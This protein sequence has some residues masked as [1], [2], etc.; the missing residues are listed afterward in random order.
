MATLELTIIDEG[1]LF[2]CWDSLTVWEDNHKKGIVYISTNE[3]NEKSGTRIISAQDSS[4]YLTDYFISD[5]Y[6]IDYE[7]YTGYWI[8]KFLDEAKVSHGTIG[9]GVAISDNTQL[10]LSSA[11]DTIQTLLQYSGWY[12]YFDGNGAAIVG[13]MDVHSGHPTTINDTRIL[14]VSTNKN[15]SMLRNRAVVWGNYDVST[16]G[17]IFAD[18]SVN[19]PWNYDSID[20]R[21]VVISNS[22]IANQVDADSLAKKVLTEFARINYEKTIA[23]VGEVNVT[24]GDF[25][26]ISSM[27]WSGT[28][29]VTTLEVS[30]SSGGLITNLTL[31]QRCPRLFAFWGEIDDYVYIGTDG[32]GVWRKPIDASGW[33]SFN[34]L[35]PTDDYDISDL[36][37]NDKIFATIAGSGELYYRQYDSPGWIPYL[38]SGLLDENGTEISEVL[39]RGLTI[40][41]QTNNIIVGYNNII[42]SGD[43]TRCWVVEITPSGELVRDDIV[44]VA[45]GDYGTHIVDLDTNDVDNVISV[46]TGGITFVDSLGSRTNTWAREEADSTTILPESDNIDVYEDT[47]YV[48]NSIIVTGYTTVGKPILQYLAADRINAYYRCSR[49]FGAAPRNV[50]RKYKYTLNLTSPPTISTSYTDVAGP[51][52]YGN[53]GYSYKE[54]D[55]DDIIYCTGL[56]E[57]LSHTHFYHEV[58]DF[59]DSSYTWDYATEYDYTGLT[60]LSTYQ[61]G[62]K[63]WRGFY[64]ITGTTLDVYYYSYDQVTGAI[65]SY[66]NTVTVNIPGVTSL[67]IVTNVVGSLFSRSF[68]INKTGTDAIFCLIVTTNDSRILVMHGSGVSELKYTQVWAKP[69]EMGGYIQGYYAYG[70]AVAGDTNTNTGINNYYAF[71]VREGSA[72]PVYNYAGIIYAYIDDTFAETITKEFSPGPMDEAAT[73]LFYEESTVKNLS[74][75]SSKYSSTP[76]G[77]FGT[78]TI[79][80]RNARTQEEITPITPVGLG[81]GVVSVAYIPF[82]NHYDF[83]NILFITSYDG[84]NSSLTSVRADTGALVHIF[85]DIDTNVQNF[86][87]SNGFIVTGSTNQTCRFLYPSSR[88]YYYGSGGLIL[89][90]QKEVFTPI[91]TVDSL[92]QV[93]ISKPYPIEV[94]NIT[95]SGIYPIYQADTAS[96]D[97]TEIV[98]TFDTYDGRVFDVQVPDSFIIASGVV[99]SGLRYF[100]VVTGD[101]LKAYPIDLL[102]DSITV[103]TFSGEVNHLETTN[104]TVNPY[105]FVSTSGDNPTFLQRNPLESS[106]VDYS[107][108]IPSAEIT[109]IRC[110]DFL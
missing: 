92:Y 3:R 73:L 62:S 27:G 29:L 55:N 1:T 10:G 45:S 14:S 96:G 33:E 105:I 43:Y 88:E 9:T 38:P 35:L 52:W 101:Y 12:L 17:Q 102:S 74:L 59:S 107:I 94:F 91:L 65:T 66:T 60:M 90:Q 20:K 87:C 78:G 28:G 61:I 58:Y 53:T 48:L 4:K 81:N 76:L 15:D 24:V 70:T 8:E 37:I 71:R 110:D 84:V 98:P 86:F 75:I 16:S 13:S 103:A 51:A 50:M 63:I 100:G 22:A 77:V 21:A 6:T 19:T 82:V 68:A 106:F 109:I 49:A 36:Y 11:Y 56:Y 44:Y 26:H 89:R 34:E 69:E 64:K 83:D 30:F 85:H 25:V 79:Y 54:D 7:S 31:D 42:P 41:H 99:P 93:E 108:G 5:S 72:P 80:V 95:T 39:A 2:D 104:N 97:F 32:S 40:N 47:D 18:I 57:W 46:S 23:V 67:T